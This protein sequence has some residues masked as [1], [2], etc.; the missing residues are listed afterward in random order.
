MNG[1]LVF[2]NFLLLL[3][4]RQCVVCVRAH[5]PG[6]SL[7]GFVLVPL[8]TGNL[9]NPSVLQFPHLSNEEKS[10]SIDLRE[11]QWFYSC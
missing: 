3:H 8:H 9:L 1:S 4:G 11:F 2:S 10:G 5:E 6:T 7:P